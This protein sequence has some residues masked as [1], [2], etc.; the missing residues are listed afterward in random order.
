MS[1]V[2]RWLALVAA[3]ALF[4]W[5]FLSVA[6]I[7]SASD[8]LLTRDLQLSVRQFVAD[9]RH[10]MAGN[11]PI[12]MPGF[13]AIAAAAWYWARSQSIPRLVVEGTAALLA[14]CGIA[15]LA[16]PHGEIAANAA[17]EQRFGLGAI[18][19]QASTWGPVLVGAGT[20]V[21][22]T[23][24]VVA[25][26]LALLLRTCRPFLLVPLPYVVLV[27]TRPWSVNGLLAL[28][29]TRAAS[30]DAI[31]IGSILAIPILTTVFVKTT[32][33]GSLRTERAPA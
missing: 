19:A 27:F 17:F 2:G 14:G 18:E 22:W 32:R 7:E 16:A 33:R 21:C 12:Y 25:S 5:M 24:F 20:A 10:G 1:R 28:W 26:R 8:G 15:W 3:D 23:I 6:P 13:F 9:W 11:S 30:G 29:G 4:L 31:A